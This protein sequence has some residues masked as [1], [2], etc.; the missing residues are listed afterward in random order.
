MVANMVL[1]MNCFPVLLGFRP[2][3]LYSVRLGID[4]EWSAMTTPS[5]RSGLVVH[6]SQLLLVGGLI[7][8]STA[9]KI[10]TLKD[11][12]FNVI[13][14]PMIE[15]VESPSVVS[16]RSMLF[17]TSNAGIDLFDYS[18][19]IQF[20]KHGLWKVVQLPSGMCPFFDSVLYKDEW[21]FLKEDKEIYS[22]SL[23]LTEEL[24]AKKT[25]LPSRPSGL[26]LHALLGAV[27]IRESTKAVSSEMII[28]IGEYW[29]W[30]EIPPMS[31]LICTISPYTM[32]WVEIG[33]LPI[34]TCFSSTTLPTGD[35]VVIG[36]MIGGPTRIYIS[37]TECKY[38]N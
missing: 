13:L 28:G 9:K 38:N 29:S 32:S 2:G 18:T 36:E 3:K 25:N 34:S 5:H 11:K 21:Y 6:D 22:I 15:G 12:K 10:F 30:P 8:E 7:G 23:A 26:K 4:S 19:P 24:Q 27:R 37:R 14:P 35:L 33:D 20:L 17:V 31:L 1:Y 16:Y